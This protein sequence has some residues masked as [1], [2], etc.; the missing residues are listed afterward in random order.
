MPR[1]IAID[2]LASLMGVLA[3]GDRIRLVEELRLGERDVNEL[4]KILDLAQARVSQHLAL[5]RSHRVVQKRK[6]G[7]H[8]YYSL[9]HE[10]I[11]GW[12]VKGLDFIEAEIR[13]NDDI[14]KELEELRNRWGSYG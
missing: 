5:L 10:H 4:S 8:A 7:R 2:E 11:A 6:E 12:L 9:S 14:H 3:H 1:S 13:Q